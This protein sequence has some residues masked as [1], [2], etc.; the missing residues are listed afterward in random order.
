MAKPPQLTQVAGPSVPNL[1]APV[2]AQEL[3]GQL[4]QFA[5][6]QQQKLT[7][8]AVENQ[9]LKASRAATDAVNKARREGRQIS[10]I[11]LPQREGTFLTTQFA[12]AYNDAARSVFQAELNSDA[13][14]AALRLREKFKFE[15]DAFSKAWAGYIDSTTQVIEQNPSMGAEAAAMMRESFLG[16]GSD[17]R[18]KMESETIQHNLNTQRAKALTLANEFKVVAQ[19]D[20]RD[21]VAGGF[22]SEGVNVNNFDRYMD[23]FVLGNISLAERAHADLFSSKMYEASEVKNQ[24]DPIHDRTYKEAIRHIIEV[25][26]PK[27]MALAAEG[28]EKGRWFKDNIVAG[29]LGAELREK[30][31]ATKSPEVMFETLLRPG[32]LISIHDAATGEASQ[33]VNQ[34]RPDGGFDYVIMDESGQ[35]QIPSIAADIAAQ[36]QP[37][38]IQQRRYDKNVEAVRV[39][40]AAGVGSISEIEDLE[41]YY[42]LNPKALESSTTE[43]FLKVLSGV[44]SELVKATDPKGNPADAAV[45]HS[46]NKVISSAQLD[47][48]INDPEKFTDFLFE[49]RSLAFNRL[50][51]RV[52][53]DSIPLFATE[54]AV[55]INRSIQNDV[56]AGRYSKVL[57]TAAALD[58]AAAR[59]GMSIEDTLGFL[60]KAGITALE[61]SDG[62]YSIG[63]PLQL[64]VPL[65]KQDP[66]LGLAVMEAAQRGVNVSLRDATLKTS[67]DLEVQSVLN[68]S[69]FMRAF[70]AVNQGRDVTANAGQLLTQIAY[71][72]AADAADPT[73]AADAAKGMLESVKG[74]FSQNLRLYTQPNGRTVLLSKSLANDF[75]S[76]KAV[77]SV[78]DTVTDDSTSGGGMFMS[79]IFGPNQK[80][81]SLY[82]AAIDSSTSSLIFRDTRGQPLRWPDDLSKAPLSTAGFYKAFDID[83][84]KG[85]TLVPP[86]PGQPIQFKVRVDTGVGPSV[87]EPQTTEFEPSAEAL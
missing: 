10:E 12:D 45:A 24:I 36:G 43:R 87:K 33:G 34:A 17:V 47:A 9:A 40:I 16:L 59:N 6:D 49:R 81:A 13:K 31:S 62:G 42:T 4:D 26:D 67:V 65:F 28:I 2:N 55:N 70:Q 68:D 61:S 5:K 74:R 30:L 3:I 35:I 48:A 23:E 54:D 15:P 71:G 78:I 38:E 64:A 66:E 7:K 20:T 37:T 58:H 73:Q 27:M 25:G 32:A 1:A 57:Q 77:R 53:L 72:A 44:R 76:D 21:P 19:D 39:N 11:D 86:K 63:A 84:A 22:D 69:E 80:D 18:V 75:E 85:V 50:E 8:S 83:P 56:R 29:R 51:G 46:P 60:S 79:R 41:R 14:S 82:A 52:P